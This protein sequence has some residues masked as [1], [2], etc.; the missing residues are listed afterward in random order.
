ME[1][2][3]LVWVATVHREGPCVVVDH[4]WYDLLVVDVAARN[5]GYKLSR[6]TLVPVMILLS[7]AWRG[8]ETPA[9]RGAQRSQGALVCQNG[10]RRTLEALRNKCVRQEFHV[11]L[12]R[13]V[14]HDPQAT[15]DRIALGTCGKG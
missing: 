15:G 10:L 1:S 9:V 2:Y 14:G 6:L 12:A 8:A 5:L 13:D 7:P 3:L 4:S 11:G